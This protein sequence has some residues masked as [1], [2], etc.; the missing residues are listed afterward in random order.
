MKKKII[1]VLSV[2]VLLAVRILGCTATDPITDDIYIEGDLYLWDG[3]AWVAVA[4]GVGAGDVVGPAGATDHALVRYDG[5]TGKLIEDSLGTTLDDFANLTL[6]GDISAS[7]I[8]AGN[9]VN[10]T[11]DLDVTDNADVG[12]DLVVVGDISGG[13]FTGIE[14]DRVEVSELGAATYDDA[15]D[16]INF[17]GDRTILSGGTITATLP[18]DGTIAV[19]ACTAWAKVSDN[20]TAVGNFFD[21]AGAAGVALT[22]Q[23][24]NYIYLDYNAGV[25]QIVVSTDILTHGFKQDH[26]HVGTVFRNGIVVHFHQEDNIGIGRV[27]IV[28]MYHLEKGDAERATGLITTDGGLLALSITAGVIYEGLSR[29]ATIVDGSTWSTWY[30]SDSGATW[31]E[32]TAQ[33]AINNTQYN[34]IAAGLAALTANRY[35]VHWV[36]CD[37]DGENLHIV[38]G[39]GDYTAN[40][41]VD[42]AVPSVLPN[43]VTNYG[44]LIAKVIVKKGTT[45]LVIAYPWTSA[46]TSS[47]ATD[48]GSLAGLADDDHTQY[49]AEVDFNAKGD[50]L[51]ATADD[52]PVIL[53][54]GAD[55][56]VLTAN[57]GV[58]NGI[59]WAAPA[60]GGGGVSYTELSGNVMTV[61]NTWGVADGVWYNWD[62]SGTLPEGTETAEIHVLKLVASDSVGVRA[63]GS[64]LAREQDILKAQVMTFLVEVEATRIVELQSDDVSDSDVFSLW[65]YWD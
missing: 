53:T 36:Y 30:T 4:V 62:L 2:S 9:D 22:N 10:V 32:V 45:T 26:I 31:T 3:G 58:A 14:A 24:T 52:T 61:S 60:G 18:A 46:F 56:F 49:V 34:A 13:T 16:Y 57:S 15:Q 19:A 29:H 6:G 5:V 35:A 7:D 48:H 41:A 43:L 38:Y 55:T 25:P 20:V 8:N 21:Y 37:I 1:S 65:G 44:V 28:D 40:Q 39:Q 47:L 42:A 51:T 63:D 12:G 59:E 27:N 64:A 23:L 54:V 33:A 11:N 50:L 17:F